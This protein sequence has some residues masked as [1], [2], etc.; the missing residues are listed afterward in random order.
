MIL[1]TSNLNDKP[2]QFIIDESLQ[3]RLLKE[4]RD[5]YEFVVKSV[6]FQIRIVDP[7][8]A[9]PN[10]DDHTRIVLGFLGFV[11]LSML[12]LLM[13]KIYQSIMSGSYETNEKKKTQVPHAKQDFRILEVQIPLDTKTLPLRIKDTKY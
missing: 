9:D 8:P 2:G 4:D 3:K 5:V 1:I 13:C 7:F 11:V 10:V 6:G 12:L